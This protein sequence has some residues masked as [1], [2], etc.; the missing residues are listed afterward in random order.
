MR[1]FAGMQ[2]KILGTA[3]GDV[4]DEA[5][6]DGDGDGFRRGRNGKDNV[7]VAAS[8]V[9]D[10]VKKAGKVSD[11]LKATD[12]LAE[13]RKS[14]RPWK[15]LLFEHLP[16][17]MQKDFKQ[18]YNDVAARMNRNGA[19][20]RRVE[21]ELGKK[22]AKEGDEIFRDG[23]LTEAAYK[24][25][26][27]EEIE[28]HL[29]IFNQ[30]L[31][32]GANGEKYQENIDLAE[33]IY[34]YDNK[35]HQYVKDAFKRE[36]DKAVAAGNGSKFDNSFS[37][38][39]KAIDDSSN[40][41]FA[42][43]M[44]QGDY[45]NAPMGRAWYM[46][47]EGKKWE[48]QFAIAEKEAKNLV[49][50]P[51][52][53][54]VSF[55]DAALL[56]SI[57]SD[58]KMKNFFEAKK[59]VFDA[60]FDEMAKYDKWGASERRKYYLNSRLFGEQNLFGFPVGGFAAK[61]RPIYALLMPDGLRATKLENGDPFDY[62]NVGLV[63]KHTVEERSRFTAGD[64]LN[65]K[66]EGAPPIND[67]SWM[68]MIS[69]Q[70]L[71][72]TA[73]GRRES[74]KVL[75]GSNHNYIEAQIIG[76]ISVGDISYI[77]VQNDSILSEEIKTRLK[78]MGI[79]V[80]IHD[81]TDIYKEPPELSSKAAP[82]ADSYVLLATYGNRKLFVPNIKP[83]EDDLHGMMTVGNGKRQRVEN[84]AAIM[85]FGNWEFV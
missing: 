79:P 13:V 68:G 63:M 61:H 82:K 72:M 57:L 34:E 42:L 66:F 59:N 64:S 37:K 50:N 60:A 62:G 81:S 5:E 49:N 78:E 14:G 56:G 22:Y 58:G 19:E 77:T 71:A 6:F 41:Q 39:K 12:D 80:V 47:Y 31:L 20:W 85:K 18:L 26:P 16:P 35:Y 33:R 43:R 3:I 40:F 23:R 24:L 17:D 29:E 65:W 10:A 45:V 11:I 69:R 9:V 8:A 30:Y 73:D 2:V 4:G 27:K 55:I 83:K 51:D 74:A 1:K 32:D 44:I 21:A 36:R 46:G 15:P 70:S 28:K 38:F 75:N 25:I 53:R 52:K 54:I 7:P 67:P 76:G 84:V 48:D